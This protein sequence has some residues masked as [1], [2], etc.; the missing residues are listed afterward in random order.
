MDDLVRGAAH[1]REIPDNPV[2]DRTDG[3]EAPFHLGFVEALPQARLHCVGA[4]FENHVGS[5]S[6][7]PIMA[8]AAPPREELFVRT[9]RT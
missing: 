8:Q 4:M 3:I 9:V 5:P 6:L 7:D 1:G 2:D